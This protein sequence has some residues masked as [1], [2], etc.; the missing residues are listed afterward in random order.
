M[1]IDW[2]SGWLIL[3]YFKVSSAVLPILQL[4]LRRILIKTIQR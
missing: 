2:L 1:M 3:T 4:S